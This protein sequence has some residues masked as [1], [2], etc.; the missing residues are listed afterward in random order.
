[1]PQIIIYQLLFAHWYEYDQ[2]CKNTPFVASFFSEEFKNFPRLNKLAIDLMLKKRKKLLEEYVLV[3]NN[4][5]A[6][7]QVNGEWQY[8]LKDETNRLQ[9][10]IAFKEWEQTEV[11]AYI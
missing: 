9:F 6:H 8:K 1:M 10:N 11:S 7:Q 3:E 2:F 4:Q 5:Y